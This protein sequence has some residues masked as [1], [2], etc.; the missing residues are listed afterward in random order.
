VFH[1]FTIG[2]AGCH[3]AAIAFVVVP[4]F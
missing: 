1:M 3:L 4:K 2:G